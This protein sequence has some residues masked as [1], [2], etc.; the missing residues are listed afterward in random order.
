MSYCLCTLYCEDNDFIINLENKLKS[1]FDRV[2]IFD[3][4][5][6]YADE[7]TVLK[8]FN[9][10]CYYNPD[11]ELSLYIT[12]EDSGCSWKYENVGGDSVNTYESDFYN[13]DETGEEIF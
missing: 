10:L 13:I 1:H 3:G 4:A 8:Y 7:D 9:K 5:S 12:D 11:L 6:F 2:E